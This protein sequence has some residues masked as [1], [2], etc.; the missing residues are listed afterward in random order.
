MNLVQ[1]K[2]RHTQQERWLATIGIVA[3]GAML[4]VVW[5]VKHYDRDFPT[6]A[7]GFSIIGAISVLVLRK[8]IIPTVCEVCNFDL[9]DV[10]HLVRNQEVLFCPKCGNKIT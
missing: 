9:S 7:I 8:T 10:I 1:I 6:L 3:I 5:L 4:F 2:K